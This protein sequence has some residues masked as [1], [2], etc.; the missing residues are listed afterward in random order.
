MTTSHC[1]T[2]YKN[3]YTIYAKLKVFFQVQMFQI[4]TQCLQT[5]SSTHGKKKAAV[6]LFN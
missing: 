1:F 2:A 5:V 4:S 6:L 3:I